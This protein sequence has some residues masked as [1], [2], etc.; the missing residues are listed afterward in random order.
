VPQWYQ[1]RFLEP[2]SPQNVLQVLSLQATVVRD[3]R[4]RQHTMPAQ[5]RRAISKCFATDDLY[6]LQFGSARS[7]SIEERL[8]GEIDRRG[9]AAVDY[10][11]SFSHPSMDMFA[12]HALLHFM[13]S[14]KLRTPK[15]LAWLAQELRTS[16]PN[17]RLRAMVDYQ[18]LFV[19]IWGEA[20]WQIADASQS[21]TKFLLTDH[22]VTVYNRALG[23]RN[24]Q[25]RPPNDPDIRLHGS[26][27]LFPLG[28]EKILILTNLSWARNPHRSPTQLRPNP[29]FYRDSI[30]NF[31]DV[32]TGRSLSEDEVRQINF[33]LKS[34]A[35]TCIAAAKA[36]WLYPEEY[37]T[38]SDWNTFG[39]GNLLMPDPRGLHPVAQVLLEYDDGSTVAYDDYGRPS[40]DPAYGLD[41]QPLRG[42]TSL[43]TFQA[44]FERLFGSEPRGAP[45]MPGS[46]QRR[47]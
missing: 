3:S 27:T 30:F 45:Y 16:S 7:T 36:E 26:H 39:N 4:G 33:I 37:V 2:A 25:C 8:F 17:R 19:S 14:Q 31:F 32:H 15:G 12:F 24:R 9:A 44:E 22:P 23:P 5:R 46:Q 42:R 10:W 43:R 21:P 1:K 18:R 11:S 28:L 20:V 34:R 6:T 41:D 35:Y 38:K 47:A 29:T 40:E 13:S